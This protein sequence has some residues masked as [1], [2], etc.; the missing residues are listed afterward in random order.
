VSR[1]KTTPQLNRELY[2]RRCLTSQSPHHYDL[3]IINEHYHFMTS[4]D[5]FPVPIRSAVKSNLTAWCC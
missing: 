5:R 2:G 3:T 1:R 4:S